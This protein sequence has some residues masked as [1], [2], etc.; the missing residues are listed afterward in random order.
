MLG[1]S[2]PVFAVIPFK[3]KSVG[4]KAVSQISEIVAEVI[5]KRRKLVIIQS[6]ILALIGLDGLRGRDVPQ[7][8]APE[9]V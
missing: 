2:V 9:S 5:L 1:T 8:V 6:T 4:V 3:Q 7:L